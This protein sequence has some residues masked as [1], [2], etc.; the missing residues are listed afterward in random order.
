VLIRLLNETDLVAFKQIRLRCL[1]EEP[2]AFGADYS[3]G[4]KLEDQEFLNRIAS[5]E[6]RFVLGVFAPSLE[7]VAGFVRAPG[8][9]SRHKGT[10]WGVY[11]TPEWRG[12]GIAGQLIREVI[13]RASTLKDIEIV[14]LSVVNSNKSALRLYS[15]LGFQKYG[16]E[17]A[18]LKVGDR[19]V[20]EDL[21][22]LRLN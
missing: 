17:I 15:S 6:D 22:A 4:L 7:G 1:K 18:A 11:L 14:Q 2:E 3:E 12:K 9:K 13:Q 16:T 19:Y 20:D 21:M 8:I 10:V 5:S